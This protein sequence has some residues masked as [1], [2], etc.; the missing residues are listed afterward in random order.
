MPSQWYC[1]LDGVASGPF[2]R[3]ELRFL[4]ERGRL[5]PRDRVREGTDGQWVAADSVAGVFRAAQQTATPAAAKNVGPARQTNAS[6]MANPREQTEEPQLSETQPEETDIA[7]ALPPPLPRQPDSTKKAVLAGTG[8][9]VFVALVL[10][11]VLLLWP[12]FGPMIAGGGGSSTGDSAGQGTGDGSGNGDGD[13]NGDSSNGDGE[14]SAPAATDSEKNESG[15][16]SHAEQPPTDQGTSGAQPPKEVPETPEQTGEP[17]TAEEPTSDSDSFLIEKLPD[18]AY[19]DSDSKGGGNGKQYVK[20]SQKW[21]FT[22]QG[23]IDGGQKGASRGYLDPSQVSASPWSISRGGRSLRLDWEGD[24]N[25]KGHNPYTQNASATAKITVER[26]LVMSVAWTGLGETQ[27]ANFDVMSFYLNGDLV[28]SAHAPGGGRGCQGGMA[29]IVSNPPPPQ[30]IQLDPGLNTIKITA[31]TNDAQYHSGA[32][33][34]FE[35]SYDM[36]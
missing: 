30:R 28:G 10:L 23:F 32:W 13:G 24:T 22:D 15:G 18:P 34:S 17:S 2:T 20:F 27:E 21:E 33:Y 26:S 29:A 16:E 19:V 4:A 6:S 11:L 31:S 36:P 8:I 9:G 14:G 25:C 7:A 3:E 5:S 1:Q 12:S 35:L